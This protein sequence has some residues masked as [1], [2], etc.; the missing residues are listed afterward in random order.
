MGTATDNT[1]ESRDI[2]VGAVRGFAAK[3][4]FRVICPVC[5]SAIGLV[6][7]GTEWDTHCACGYQWHLELRA[8]GTKD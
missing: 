5:Q 2:D 4:V 3:T 7:G 1:I 6:Q 8:V